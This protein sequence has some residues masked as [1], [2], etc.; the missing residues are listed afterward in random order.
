MSLG[1]TPPFGFIRFFARS[2]SSSAR[3]ENREMAAEIGLGPNSYG[4]SN[5][6]FLRVVKD[7]PKHE[8][9][10]CFECLS[11]L[12]FHEILFFRN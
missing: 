11:Y 5:V 8:V 2:L 6:R 1:V 10:V 12:N 7:S 9:F 4:K 3:V